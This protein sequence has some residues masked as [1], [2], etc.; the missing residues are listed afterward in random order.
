MAFF[1][2]VTGSA[3]S[4][5]RMTADEYIRQYKDAAI[6][7]MKKTGVPASI[8]LAQGMFE[9]DYGNSPLAKEANNHF[10]I[11]CHKEWDG[12]VY[13]QD[14]DAKDECFRKYEKVQHSYDDH[15]EFLRSRERYS[16]LFQL[17][18]ADYKGWAHGLKKAGYATNPQYANRIIDII[19]RYNLN[20][21][22]KGIDPVPAPVYANA[23]Q[24]PPVASPKKDKSEIK[25]NEST[26]VSA[27]KINLPVLTSEN[28]INEVPFVRAKKGDSWL[29]IAT[30]NQLELW[31]I[32]EY[33]DV[34]KNKILKENDIVYLRPKKARC[35]QTFHIVQRGE[36]LHQISQLY[37][38]R[39]SKLYARNHLHAGAEPATGSKVYLKMNKS[40]YE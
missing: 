8:T 17:D 20:D 32:L 38:V 23:G 35:E 24:Q 25:E 13:H 31:E 15:S 33:N 12:P 26:S 39:V 30:D 6:Q 22:D 7:D 21:L 34:D 2:A 28:T 14:D 29:K 9:S 3:F 19:E 37:G 40:F 36:T 18:I 4:Q 5:S 27:V 16:S 1:I 11:K 10:G